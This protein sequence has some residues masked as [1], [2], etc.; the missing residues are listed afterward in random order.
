MA[1]GRPGTSQKT[2]V[3]VVGR[4]LCGRRQGRPGAPVFLAKSSWEPGYVAEKFGKLAFAK[5]WERSDVHS[6]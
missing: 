1:G 6:E 2:R 3:P 5:A 4:V